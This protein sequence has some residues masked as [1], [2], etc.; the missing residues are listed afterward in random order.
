MLGHVDKL[1]FCDGDDVG[2]RVRA[3]QERTWLVE[4]DRLLSLHFKLL[5]CAWFALIC[6]MCVRSKMHIFLDDKS[7]IHVA[8]QEISLGRHKLLL[9]LLVI[10]IV[11]FT[12]PVMVKTLP[13]LLTAWCALDLRQLDVVEDFQCVVGFL[14]EDWT[15]NNYL[16]AAHLIPFLFVVVRG[17]CTCRVDNWVTL[18]RAMMPLTSCNHIVTPHQ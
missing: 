4:N 11:L 14:F 17:G 18:P 9:V 8:L 1:V 3:V 5:F 7:W 15:C 10:S 6:D 13:H 12:C 16:M 2:G